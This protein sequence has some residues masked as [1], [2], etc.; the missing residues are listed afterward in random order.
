MFCLETVSNSLTNLWWMGSQNLTRIHIN[1]WPAAVWTTPAGQIWTVQTSHETQPWA[2]LLRQHDLSSLVRKKTSLPCLKMN[3][4]SWYLAHKIDD[5]GPHWQHQLQDISRSIES[6]I[7]ALCGEAIG[8]AQYSVM[9]TWQMWWF[10]D[11]D[12]ASKQILHKTEY[13]FVLQLCKAIYTWSTYCLYII[14]KIT[15]K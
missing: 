5:I 7:Q 15:S 4:S 13:L 14:K 6:S 1:I 2:V 9:E 11:N 10:I 3:S 8:T 12:C